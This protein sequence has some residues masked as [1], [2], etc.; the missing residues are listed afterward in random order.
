MQGDPSASAIRI[1]INGRILSESASPFARLGAAELLRLLAGSSD[2]DLVLVIPDDVAVPD[3]SELPYRVLPRADS[4]LAEAAFDHWH[5]PGEAR[6][7]AAQLILCLHASAPLASPAPV[8]SLY[9]DGD[10]LPGSDLRGGRLAQ[11][12]ALGGLRGAVS[13]LRMQDVPV[14]DHRLSW[15]A[16]PPIVPGVFQ[17]GSPADDRRLAETLD[18]PEAYVLVAGESET[19]LPFLFAGWT[20]VEGSMGESF[21]LLIASAPGSPP[22]VAIETANRLGGGQ[23]VRT[24]DVPD[25]A[26]PAVF[27]GASAL[28]HGG[29]RRNAAA[30]RWALAS[31]LP[32]AA[33]STPI[34]DSV[35]GPAGFLVADGD[36]RSLGAA[37]LTMLVEDEVAGSLRERGLERAT[38][39]RS[40]SARRAWVEALTSFPRA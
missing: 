33:P 31:G 14:E 21:N 28:L 27:R 11:A 20:W 13:V 30:L 36:S 32:V 6:R 35:L 34:T 8:I 2:L 18:L 40:E 38:A 24:L 15:I 17:A 22:G 7:L 16:L 5:F 26:W 12:L 10:S 1:V 9:G 37:C 4:P 3:G 29:G 19:R 25:E 23:A 39:Y